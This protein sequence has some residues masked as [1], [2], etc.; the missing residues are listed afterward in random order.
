M[1]K[2]EFQH[3]LK[4]IEERKR[5]RHIQMARGHNDFNPLTVV[6]KANDEIHLHSAMIGAL[7][8]P[9]GLHYQGPL[10]LQLFLKAARLEAFGLD[11][12]RTTV[13]VEWME[14]DLFLSDGEKHLIIENKIDAEDQPCQLTK[15][16]NS[17]RHHFRLEVHD[18]IVQNLQVLYLTK[19][20]SRQP[21]DHCVSDGLV[22][23]CGSD[24]ALK[25]CSERAR[26]Q[27][28]ISGE[29]QRYKA[30]Y[31]AISYRVEILQWLQMCRE[32]VGQILNL[33]EAL[34]CYT[35]TVR[36]IT[37]QYQSKVK[38]MNTL[39]VENPN[40][41]STAFQAKRELHAMLGT[42]LANLFAE[43][44]KYLTDTHHL[45]EVKPNNNTLQPPTLKAC[46][47]WFYNDE[48]IKGHQKI[49][50]IGVTFVLNDRY[51]LHIEAATRH[52]HVG[53]ISYEIKKNEDKIHIVPM[54]DGE[55]SLEKLGLV[56]RNWKRGKHRWYSFDCGNFIDGTNRE[57]LLCYEALSEE[58]VIR[59]RI[60]AILE[61]FAYNKADG[62]IQ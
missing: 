44:R 29:L 35:D 42:L 25:R 54:K 55:A 6:R 46:T 30:F 58:C 32:E 56:Y 52:V 7:L 41:I 12:E 28:R 36:K 53:L 5:E 31:K 19:Q 10:F 16:I 24:E 40:L 21:L 9:E 2:E 51:L 20:P 50:S 8:D 18:G 49:V 45:R 26:T 48:K 27:H 3:L 59:R 61:H 23:F 17:V 34:R 39:L 43:T 57:A 22:W 14:I 47:K 1:K 15:Y 11:P 62:R 60:D 33:G 4:A 38:P 13:R 37:R